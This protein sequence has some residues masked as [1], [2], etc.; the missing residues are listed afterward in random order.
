VTGHANPRGSRASGLLIAC[1]LAVAGFLAWSWPLAL[2]LSTHT[3][4]R[5]AV[6]DAAAGTSGGDWDLILANDQNLS[7]WGAADNARALLRGDWS[8]LLSQ[9][10]CY[11][12][13]KATL[14]GEHMFELGVLAAPWLLLTGD[15]VVAYNLSFLTALVVAAAGMFLFLHRHTGSAPAAVVGALAFAFATP[16][17]V[18]LPYHPAVIGTH[19]IP[20]VL[21]SFDG[22]L[23]GGG[24]AAAAVFGVTLLLATLVGSYPLMAVGIV[25]AAYGSAAIAQ[26]WRRGQRP[27]TA[28]ALCTVAALPAAVVIAGLLA[29]YARLQQDWLLATNPDAKFLAAAGDYL[30]GG[31]LSVG[32]AA[33]VGVVLLLVLRREPG[34]RAVP[35][36]VVATAASLALATRFVLPGGGS[37]SL[38]ETLARSITLLESVRGPGKIGLAVVFG[39]QALGA[40]GWS[41][42]MQGLGAGRATLLAAFLVALTFVEMSPPAWMRPVL[43]AGAAMQLR[44]VAP[45]RRRI[46][47]LM[48]ALQA[49]GERRAV[50]DLP[51][52]RMVKAPLELLD[53]AYHGRPTSACYNSLI[54]PTMRAVYALA[55]RSHTERGV[56]ELAAAGFGFVIERPAAS[57][58]LTTT[59]FP[60]PA[61]LI[62]F[63]DGI[64][65]WGL[66]EAGEVSG[67]VAALAMVAVG[68]ASRAPTFAPE[69]PHEVD[70]EITNRGSVMWAAAQPIEP[71]FA[72]LELAGP[73]GRVVFRSRARGVL[74]LALSP[75]ATVTVQLVMPAAPEAG[76]WRANI[77]IDGA[78]QATAAADFR[79]SDQRR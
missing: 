18:D 37:W 16:R 20:W 24:V 28:V 26:R 29:A 13:P 62:A 31:L 68:G 38:Y 63:E 64:A 9:G 5:V 6:G 49:P 23:A 50:L 4:S 10:Q 32:C 48:A 60:P 43:G 30:P 61:R 35:L 57:A 73:D 14:L 27:A 3:L 22:V 2:H 69:S 59:S 54:P 74:P 21:W 17:L 70:V 11:P 1:T 8:G 75:G 42:A 39:L 67:D 36:L 34:R 51:T 19:W 72:D 79:W 40:I 46:D 45:S 76:S 65:V 7:L 41:R 78:G 15:P 58:P 52:G 53:A 55:A 66:P 44:E 77:R 71:L 12:M 56:A 33:L 47:T 25:G